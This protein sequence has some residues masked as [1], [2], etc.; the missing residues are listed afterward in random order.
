MQLVQRIMW[1]GFRPTLIGISIGV[2]GALG[3][4]RLMQTLLFN[5]GPMIP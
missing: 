4:T 5:V 1:D 3:V 2:G